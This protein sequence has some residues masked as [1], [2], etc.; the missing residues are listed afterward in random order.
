[1]SG[2]PIGCTIDLDGPGKQLGHLRVPRSSNTSGW[3]SLTVPIVSVANG[4]GPTAVVI[5]GVHGDEPEGQVA[6]IKL[7]RELE[8]KDVTGR[9][10]VIP[11]LSPEA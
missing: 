6:A 2:S 3:S 5:G 7:A 10:I 8:P 11:C 4:D 9:V 1:M